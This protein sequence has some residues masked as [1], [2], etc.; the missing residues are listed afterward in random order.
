MQPPRKQGPRIATLVLA[1]AAGL[2]AV[3]IA[4]VVLAADG[5]DQRSAAEEC[6]EE[7]DPQVRFRYLPR[8]MAA[9][10]LD[11]QA[12]AQLNQLVAQAEEDAGA[13]VELVARRISE[14]GE[15]VGAALVVTLGESEAARAGFIRGFTRRAGERGAG[16]AHDVDVSPAE[17][18]KEVGVGGGQAGVIV[19]GFAGC[20]G[21]AVVAADGATARRVVS[22]MARAPER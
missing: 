16:A 15:P 13:D 14:G 4:V 17:D 21:V 22:S 9:Q 11:A 2:A 10:T 6:R 1:I 8:G 20:H 5:D 7:T 18:G 3:I 12:E 19:T